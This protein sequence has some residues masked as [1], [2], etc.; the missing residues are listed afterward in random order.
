MKEKEVLVSYIRRQT[1]AG[2]PLLVETVRQIANT[3]LHHRCNPYTSFSVPETVGINWVQKFYH[4][5]KD[6]RAVKIRAMDALQVRGANVR[7]L[8]E[9]FNIAKK[10]LYG[11]SIE[12]IY[13]M[14]KTSIMLR[15]FHAAKRV[16]TKNDSLPHCK[17]PST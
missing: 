12:N 9:W 16:V 15:H 3:F 13:N 6:L 11:I 2:Y 8:Q 7:R 4:Q 10:N 1:R 14:D 17:G 5:H